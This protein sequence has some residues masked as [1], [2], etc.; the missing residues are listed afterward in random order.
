MYTV[1][2]HIKQDTGEPFYVGYGNKRRPYDYNG[3]K[4]DWKAIK[5]DHG[6]DVI[7]LDTCMEKKAAVDIESYWINRIGRIVNG[8][9]PLINMSFHGSGTFERNDE[10]KQNLREYNL[11]MNKK[12]PT[13]AGTIWITDGT[14]N[15][16]IPIGADIPIGFVRG[17]HT[18]Y[19]LKTTTCP[20]CGLEG[21]G[22]GMSRFHGDNCK[23]K[24]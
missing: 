8:T 18:S 11:S 2:L 20:H 3:R 19:K 21:G 13:Q 17:R 1:Y 16:R 23:D 7:I 24:I 4:A 10:W 6:V 14:T 5:H 15:T 22:S 12:P 9:G